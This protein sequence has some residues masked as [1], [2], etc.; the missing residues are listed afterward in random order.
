MNPLL[1]KNYLSHIVIFLNYIDIINLSIC[2]KAL[3]DMLQFPKKKDNKQDKT[4]ESDISDKLSES[5]NSVYIHLINTIFLMTTIHQFFDME[6]SLYNSKIKKNLLGKNPKFSYDWKTLFIKLRKAFKRYNDD[7]IKKR[8][9]DFFKV[10]IYLPD[11]RKEIFMLEFECS[12]IHQTYNYDIITRLVYTYNYYSKYTT[13]N[14]I[15]SQSKEVGQ[16]KILREKLF[17]EDHLIKFYELFREYINNDEAK[18]FVNNNVCL[19]DFEN[20]NNIYNNNFNSDLLQNNINNIN[21][22]NIFNFILWINHIFILYNE[23]SYEYINGLSN[24]VDDDEFITEYLAKKNDL[25]NCGLLLTNHFENINIIINFLSIYQFIYEDYKKKHS[26]SPIGETIIQISQEDQKEY[27]N[28]I[29]FSPKFT[30]YNLFT[31]IIEDKFTSKL[32]IISDKFKKIIKEYFIELF[33]IKEEN[34][35]KNKQ[36]KNKMDIDEDDDDEYINAIKE[37]YDDLDDLDDISLDDKPSKKE[38]VENIMNSMVDRWINGYNSNGIM[39]TYFKMND[40][41]I[42]NYENVI[43]DIFEQV[44][45]DS[46]NI[47]KMSL[48]QCFVIVEK[49]TRCE[50]NSKTLFMNKESLCVIR[51]TKMRLM[52]HGYTIIYKFLILALEKDFLSRIIYDDKTNKIKLYLNS[53]EKIKSQD[54]NLNM[55]ALSEEGEKNVEQNI[56]EEKEMI[57]NDLIEK[58]KLN[59]NERSLAE[60]YIKTLKIDY[61]LLL[62]KVLLNYYKQMEIYKERNEKVEY[63]IKNKQKFVN[64]NECYNGN[65]EEKNNDNKLYKQNCCKE[66][67]IF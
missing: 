19:Y 6:K 64:V 26:I 31:K 15:L 14:Y 62:K 66:I 53:S 59:E 46:V 48:D 11:I 30:L 61:V 41:Y 8:V 60:E 49:V 55:D 29:V 43:I 16:I 63:F 34:E 56:K 32:N 37:E 18:T 33:T 35:N 50:G 23:L 44:I 20:L 22:R 54:Y 58:A 40:K 36:K 9:L 12:S 28:K 3:N 17:F 51:R 13:Y 5:D 25:L 65:E 42:N 47:H 7:K 67:H 24:Y 39:H 2:N 45:I 52:R 4:N 57:I 21:I 10:H 38:L 27:Y 1:N